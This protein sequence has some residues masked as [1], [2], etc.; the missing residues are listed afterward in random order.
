MTTRHRTVALIGAGPVGTALAIHARACGQQVVAVVSRHRSTS[1]ALARRVGCRAEGTSVAIIPPDVDLVTGLANRQHFLKELDRAVAEAAEGRSDL[2]LIYLEPDNYRSVLE[3]IGIGNADLL[4]SDAAELLRR[5][6][7][8]DSL[9][10]RFSD[11]TFMVLVRRA[12]H[13]DAVRLA[14]TLR[15]RFEEH[16]FE[17]GG[18]SLPLPASIGLV[19]IGEKIASADAILSSAATALKQAQDD[20][21]N[22]I[23]TYDPAAPDKAGAGRARGGAFP[24]PLAAALVVVIIGALV[25]VRRRRS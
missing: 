13:E 18:R 17:V 3:S 16:I 5:Q 24:L 1:R 15:K 2:A 11:N 9:A 8:D 6:V 4:M 25:L 14:S 21:G 20:G 22:R 7:P 19:L 23:K 12:P 10:A